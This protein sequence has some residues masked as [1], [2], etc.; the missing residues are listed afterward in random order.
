MKNE[1][2]V[3]TWLDVAKSL[4]DDLD[5]DVNDVAKRLKDF[6]KYHRFTMEE[7]DELCWIDSTWVFNQIYK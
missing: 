6:G 4:C 3:K 5:N 7:V 2:V 1:K